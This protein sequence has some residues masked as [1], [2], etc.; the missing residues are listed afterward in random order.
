M[1]VSKYSSHPLDIP[2]FPASFVWGVATS[3]YQIEGAAAEDGKGPS[4]WDTFC[5]IPGVIDNGDSGDVACDHYHR[6][7]EDVALIASLGFKAYRFSIS[8]PRV[9]PLGDGAWN[10]AGFAFYGR[11]LDELERHGI[12]PYLTLYH[13]DLPQALEDSGGW[14][15]RRTATLFAE[16]AAEVVRRFGSR[17]ASVATHNEPLVTS[18]LGHETGRFAPGLRDKRAAYLVSHHLLLSHG[19]AL[20]AMREAGSAVPL[21]IVL[22]LWPGRPADPDSPADLAMVR[23]FDDEGLRWYLDPLFGKGYPAPMI[24]RLGPDKPAI[25]R[26]DLDIIA[27][28]MDFLGVNYYSC[29]W[30]SAAT[31]PTPSPRKDDL[32]DMGWE[33]W[34]EAFRDLLLKLKAEYRLPPLYITEN[35]AAFRDEPADGRVDDGERVG[36]FAAHLRALAEAMAAGVDVRGYFAWSLMDNFEWSEGYARRF[37]LVYVD[38]ATQ[39]RV[40]KRSALWFR[41]FMENRAGTG[42]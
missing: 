42:R 24:E 8:W 4:I 12:S 17:L 36:Y 26:E 28:P 41:S 30:L 23:E 11:L 5:R 15:N 19:L 21:G 37:G 25:S 1:S 38:Y 40:P 32:T 18:I 20:T 10:E 14:R 2:S 39:G 22:S 31:P 7:A 9:R 13:W 34:P 3:S 35:G 16:Y 29:R 27:T 33:I 6:Y